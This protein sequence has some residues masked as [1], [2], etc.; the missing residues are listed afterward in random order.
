MRHVVV[1]GGG[2]AGLAAAHRVC[3]RDPAFRVT[4]LEATSRLGGSIA[5]ERTRGFLI[6]GGAESFLTEKPWAL[7]LCRRIG[8]DEQLVATRDLARRTFVVHAGKLHPLPDGFLLMAPTRLWPLATSGLFSPL[9]KLRMALDLVLPR[10]AAGGDE[11]LAS[12]VRRRLGEEALERVA[13]PLV[14]GIYTGD[15]E[16][17]SLGATM[18]RFL[19]MERRDRSVILAMRRQA[20][21]AAHRDTG[22]RWSLFASFADGMQTLVDGLTRRLPEGS[23]R[24]GMPV[25][26][27][28]RT[29]DGTWR[30]TLAGGEAIGADAVVMAAPAYAAAELLRPLDAAL[31]GLLG[32]V[33]YASSATV[34]VAYREADV[35]HPLDGF[36]FVVPASEGRALIACSFAHRKYEGRAPAGQAL[37]RV[38]MG[39]RLAPEV[40]A[41]SDD[42][43]LAAARREL[44]AL[45]GIEAAPALA[46]IHRHHRAMPQYDVGHLERVAAME[47]A[48]AALG[49][50][51]LA[52]SAYRGV[53]IPDC[54]HSGEQAADAV[55]AS[56]DAR[57]RDRSRP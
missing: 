33:D 13:Q 2:L 37:I 47:S 7:D 54:I 24:L 28:A 41:W 18:P 22:A 20:R 25:T 12:F 35:P 49:G 29:A 11:S 34:T 30:V 15:P 17:L 48:A 9:G 53:G 27:L 39:G 21:A 23:L 31:A 19:E 56:L 45:L 44:A 52:G 4:L 51:A 46:R 38:F 14:S 5:T 43:L 50:L 8:L 36:G 57:A 55:L 16:R 6:E 40:A 1:I 32:G 10:R 3:E 26:A 42:A